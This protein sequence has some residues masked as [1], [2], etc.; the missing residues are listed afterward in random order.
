MMRILFSSTPL[1]GPFGPMAPVVRAGVR[2]GH[3]AMI[4]GAM[5]LAGAAE[6]PARPSG[7]LTNPTR[8][9][10]KCVRRAH[11][12]VPHRRQ[13]VDDQRGLRPPSVGC[14]PPRVMRGD[15]LVSARSGGPRNGRVRS[16]LAAEIHD[17]P[18]TRIAIRIPIG[19]N[20]TEELVLRL[21]ASPVDELR[22][23]AGLPA[24]PEALR[25][26]IPPC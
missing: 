7:P 2:A 3:S 15:P 21:A 13:Q 23:G 11:R 22:R 24:D 17:L 6:V 1:A 26:S 4:V 12:A 19:V 10:G 16:A 8:R 9:D 14:R 18:H 5:S 25:L 20:V